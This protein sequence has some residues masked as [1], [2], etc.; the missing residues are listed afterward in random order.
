MNKPKTSLEVGMTLM[1]E[2][3][4]DIHIT[5]YEVEQAMK[6][7]L[8]DQKDK[9]REWLLARELLDRWDKKGKISFLKEFKELKWIII[10]K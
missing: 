3:P 8:A 5:D 1:K 6:S 2:I 7:A 4:F 9:I 10:P